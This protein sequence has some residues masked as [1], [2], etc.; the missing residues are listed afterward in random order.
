MNKVVVGGG[1]G[2]VKRA[3]ALF[4]TLLCFAFSSNFHVTIYLHF[5]RTLVLKQ[6]KS[7]A[8]SYQTLEMRF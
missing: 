4:Q 3:F 1:G 6:M 2:K 7:M 8:L 5:R